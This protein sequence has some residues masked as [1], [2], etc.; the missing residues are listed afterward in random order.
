MSLKLPLAYS[1]S[2]MGGGA[3]REK[4]EHLDKVCRR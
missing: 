4:E 3:E 2:R 1:E